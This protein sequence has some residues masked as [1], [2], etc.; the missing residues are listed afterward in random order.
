[1]TSPSPEPTTGLGSADRLSTDGGA[2]ERVLVPLRILERESVSEGIA[3][4]LGTTDVVVLGYHE[5]PDQTPPD[6]MRQ[7]YE[8]G[9][10]KALAEIAE[11]LREG[12]GKADTRLVFTHDRE[13]TIDRVAEEVTATAILLPN[14]VAHVETLL[15]PLRGEVDAERIARFV[16]AVRGDRDIDVTL[17]AASDETTSKSEAARALLDAAADTLAA[18]GVPDDAITRETSTTATPVQAIV[19]A[20]VAHDAVVMGERAPSWRSLVFGDLHDQI[21]AESLGPVLV[22]RRRER[23]P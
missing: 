4:L 10:Q 15:V 18:A 5:V 3:D 9:A 8:D 1:M 6:M 22:V 11:T 19:D 21:A 17:F 13:Q 14:P 12:G 7:Q 16:A 20:A 2:R 23:D